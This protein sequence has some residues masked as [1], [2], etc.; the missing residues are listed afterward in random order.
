MNLKRA[1]AIL[2]ANDVAAK[3]SFM[4]A[5]HERDRFDTASFWTLFTAL[6][7]IGAAPPRM[8]GKDAGRQ[9]SHIYHH[10]LRCII[11]HFS[12]HDLCRIRRLP[13][14]TLTAYIDRLEWVCTPIINVHQGFGPGYF[15]DRM[16]NPHQRVLDRLFRK[17][18]K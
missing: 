7:V 12:E 15:S 2:A 9:T 11:F 14:R 13:G 6:S 17:R 8:R 1:L 18:E 3:G 10:I 16:K 4:H 5:F